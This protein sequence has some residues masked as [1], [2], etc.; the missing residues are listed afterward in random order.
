MAKMVDIYVMQAVPTTVRPWLT[1]FFGPKIF[2]VNQKRTNRG[3][4]YIVLGLQMLK[5]RTISSIVRYIEAYTM[6]YM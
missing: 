2:R 6:I 4:I 3:S 1:F 5:N